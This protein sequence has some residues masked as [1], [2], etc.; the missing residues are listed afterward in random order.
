MSNDADRLIDDLFTR[1]RDT[2][3][4]TGER[5]SAAETRINS[6]LVKQPSAPYYMAQTIIMQEAAIKQLKAEL[7]AAQAARPSSG[8]FLAGLFGGGQPASAAPQAASMQAPQPGN[9]RYSQ[10]AAPSRGPSFLGGAL[11]TAAGVAGG[12]VMGN[13][14]MD[15]FSHHSPTEIVDVINQTPPLDASTAP[16]ADMNGGMDQDNLT[17]TG[18]MPGSDWGNGDFGTSGFDG[19]GFDGGGFDDGFDDFSSF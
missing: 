12:V 16:A 15:M 3:S 13:L 17:D 7:D 2:E 6:H 5:D 10:Y 19:N 14:L 4:Q 11:Q 9:N 8:G 1:L 18:F